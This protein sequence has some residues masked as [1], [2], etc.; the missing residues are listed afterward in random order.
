MKT[1][2]VFVKFK[3]SG[4]GIIATTYIR[5]IDSQWADLSHALDRD[6]E[7]SASLSM[8]AVPEWSTEILTGTVADVQ[9]GGTVSKAS[10]DTPKEKGSGE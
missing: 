2:I 5:Y 6:R 7:L 1:H 3:I 8:F 10:P 9:V 4:G